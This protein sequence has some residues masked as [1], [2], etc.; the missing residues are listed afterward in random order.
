MEY[1]LMAKSSLYW[2]PVTY[3]EKDLKNNYPKY[4]LL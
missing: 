3:Q 2:F 1:K 4:G